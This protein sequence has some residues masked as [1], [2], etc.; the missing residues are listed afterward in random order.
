MIR[1]LEHVLGF[2]SKALGSS[3]HDTKKALG[4]WASGLGQAAESVL[5]PKMGF[6]V[7]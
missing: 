5:N 7:F 2:A 1:D 4:V 3:G 6:K